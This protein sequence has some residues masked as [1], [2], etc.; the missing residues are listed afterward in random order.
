M[1]REGAGGIRL[2]IGLR[3]RTIAAVATIGTEELAVQTVHLGAADL[4]FL[5]RRF[6]GLRSV[7]SSRAGSYAKN[8]AGT[9]TRR[10]PMGPVEDAGRL[11]LPTYPK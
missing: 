10:S 11:Q 1:V 5:A 6:Q 3:V 4:A 7:S 8:P 9:R 2:R